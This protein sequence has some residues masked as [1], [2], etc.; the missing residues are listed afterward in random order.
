[1]AWSN[2]DHSFNGTDQDD[3]D[4]SNGTVAKKLCVRNAA[5]SAPSGDW[6]AEIKE[7]NA[8]AGE[9]A[10]KVVGTMQIARGANEE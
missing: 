2:P 10:L 5:A 8:A 1:M 7:T 3:M 9:R 4:S 6:R